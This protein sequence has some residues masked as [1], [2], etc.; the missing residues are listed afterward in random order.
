VR[1]ERRW[2]EK[3]CGYA[4]PCWLWQL[5]K[6]PNGYGRERV[7]GR[8]APLTLA[9]RNAYE[10]AYGAI[11][12][13]LHVDHLCSAHACVRPDHLEAVTQAEN[14]RRAFLKVTPAIVAA[15]RKSTERQVDLAA[16]YGIG[17]S[18]VSRIKRG[19]HPL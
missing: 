17:Q 2:V 14:N 15:I 13:G 6:T 16:R 19:A 9:H 11:A 18:T 3:D 7:G 10:R 12:E 1:K 8:A 4:T 5:S